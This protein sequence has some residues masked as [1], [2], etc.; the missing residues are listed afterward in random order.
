MLKRQTYMFLQ[1]MMALTFDLVVFCVFISY[2]FCCG[3]RQDSSKISEYIG[4][5]IRAGENYWNLLHNC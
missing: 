2:A 5:H 4:Q 3:L 1:L